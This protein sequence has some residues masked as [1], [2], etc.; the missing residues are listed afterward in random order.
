MIS[1][2]DEFLGMRSNR[3]LANYLGVPLRTLTCFAYSGGQFYASFPIPKKTGNAV[4]KIDAPCPKL[5][6]MQ[7]CINQALVEIYDAP[8]CVHGFVPTRS[9]VTNA[10]LHVDRPTVVKVDLKSFFP[11]ISSSR[12][13]GL[14]SSDPFSFPD[15]VCNTLTNLV[16]HNGCLPQGAPTSPVLS[17]MICYKMDC[18]L[19][20]FARSRKL[21]YT[22]YADDLTFSSSS[23]RAIRAVARED[24]DT[25]GYLLSDRLVSIIERNGFSLNEEKTAILGRGAR[26]VVTG[27]VVNKK[28]NFRRSEYRRL[29]VMFHR[30]ETKGV[31]CA[32]R[33]YVELAGRSRYANFFFTENGKFD[34]ERFVSHI[35]GLLAYFTMIERASGF[36]STPLRKLW[37]RFSDL[38]M[39][40]VPEMSASR[41]IVRI[42]SAASYRNPGERESHDY[43]VIGTGFVLSNRKLLSV[44]HCFMNISVPL[45]VY[46]EGSLALLT[47]GKEEVTV[48]Y[49]N[50][51]ASCTDDWA[52]LD[53]P[54]EF[55][56]CAGLSPSAHA[57]LQVGQ[58]VVAFGFAEGDHVLRRIEAR[59]LEVIGDAVIVDRAFVAGMSGGPVFNARGEVVGIV[60]KGSGNMM[61]D[62]DGQFI[63]LKVIP[64]IAERFYA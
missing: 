42:D 61:Y 37:D 63:A 6:E 4:R 33:G 25:R 48:N 26:Q 12:I 36:E 2:R 10:A 54:E 9:I 50:L 7:R 58:K 18:A 24:A 41:S 38:T 56:R 47:L 28:C 23:K 35:E 43:G 44:A 13:H 1:S 53:M 62:R 31:E 45:A 64:Q 30:W 21:R 49:E 29:R 57:G 19:Q 15:E 5:K 51:E 14:F 34:K 46:D 39:G 55:S 52:I 27:V 32:A 8:G 20:S 22:R 3:D 17:N 59:V 40:R 11:S 60:T 16:C